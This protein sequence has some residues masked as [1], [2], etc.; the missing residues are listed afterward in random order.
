VSQS[1]VSSVNPA[2]TA[3]PA[4]RGAERSTCEATARIAVAILAAGKSRRMHSNL[5][6]H[7]HDVA[8]ETIFDRVLHAALAVAPHRTFAVVSPV[9]ADHLA[10][11]AEADR[12][13]AIVQDPPLGTA[14]AVRLALD[15]APDCDLLVSLLGDNPLL[16]GEVIQ[17]LI[18][19]ARATGARLTLLTCVLP[20]AAAYGRIERDGEGR[21]TRIVERKQDRDEFRQGETEINSGIMVLNAHWAREALGRVELDIAC[22]EYLLTDLIALAVA[23]HDGGPIWPVT[24]VRAHRDVALGVNDRAQLAEAANVAYDRIRTRHMRQ[25][26]TI[27]G[28]ETVFIDEGVEIA[29]DTT[30]LPF[31]IISGRTTIGR[32]CV[33]GPH[34]VL[35]NAV[36]GDSVTVRSSTITRSQIESGSDVGPYSHLREGTCIGPNVHVGNFA[37]MKHTTVRGGAKVGHVSYLGD[38]TVGEG[39][40]IGAGAITANFDGRDKHPTA[41]GK[42]S[43]VGSGTVFVAPASL[44]DQAK[45][46][47]GAVVKG[48]VPAGETVVGVPARPIRRHAPPT[49]VT[50]ED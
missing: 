7:L 47:A 45:T 35:E 23:E 41:I 6:K 17:E 15:T 11:H 1:Q 26:V 12:F 44:G 24:A 4:Q 27:V 49:D 46:G 33:I 5:P 20:D 31:S 8:G 38:A 50:G 30:I 19:S 29:P 18:D 42:E 39:A 36:I 25:G 43:F 3:R 14:D 10:A 34:T 16:T 48:D 2:A 21:V 28:P 22:G 13:E 9:L 40:N 32:D 37:E